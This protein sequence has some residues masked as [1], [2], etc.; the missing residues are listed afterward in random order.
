VRGKTEEQT[1]T[2]WNTRTPQWQDI[3]SAPKDG[4][5]V[6]LIDGGE[7]HKYV[8]IVHCHESAINKKAC[9]NDEKGEVYLQTSPDG[10]HRATHWMPIPNTPEDS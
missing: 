2:K 4:G 9:F 1:I 7:N 3:S 6:I 5:C 10:C 8:R